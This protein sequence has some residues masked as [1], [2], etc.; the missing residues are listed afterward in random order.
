MSD[1]LTGRLISP[2]GR[3]TARKRANTRAETNDET[4]AQR[5]PGPPRPPRPALTD[6]DREAIHAAIDALPPMTDEQ[7]EAIAEVIIAARERRRHTRQ[8]SRGPR[9]PDADTHAGQRPRSG[10]MASHCEMQLKKDLLDPVE[11]HN[12]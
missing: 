7:I 3:T 10:P 12:H 8:T 6:A 5:N 4:N 2:P 11:H 9:T 1:R